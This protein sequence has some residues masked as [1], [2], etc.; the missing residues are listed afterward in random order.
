MVWSF[1]AAKAFNKCQRQWYYQN[2]LANAKARDPLRRQ[3]YLLSKLQSINSW[4]GRI[5]DAVI[6]NTIVRTLNAK[7][8]PSLLATQQQ[9]RELF[10]RQLAFARKHPL[11]RAGFS[12]SGAGSD[13]AV[14]HCLEYGGEIP[15]G[16]IERARAEI[17]RA[18]ENLFAMSE[19]WSELRAAR[20]LVS[21]RPLSFSHT[22]ETVRAVPDLIAFYDRKPPLIVDW[23]V[24][25]F[26]VYRAE[27]QLG[28]YAL[29]LVRGKP[30]SDFPTCQAWEATDLRLWEVQ[31]L[32]N[33][34]RRYQLNESRI[35]E[36]DRFMAESIN[37]MQLLVGNAKKFTLD[38][39]ELLTTDAPETCQSCNHRSM[40]WE[41]A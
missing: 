24:H 31:L 39:Q 10:D 34:I 28:I 27:M 33:K 17:D 26:G 14:F 6:S 22:G 21:Q 13:F 35:S 4:R 25:L 7:K 18:L 29:A 30:H 9:A 1:S 37:E 19:V 23:K 11:H 20:Y 32:T 41:S 3:A 16:E 12:P 36:I 5:V 40:C 38:P 2:C 8:N 15:E